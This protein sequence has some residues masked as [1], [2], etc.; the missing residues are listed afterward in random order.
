M[1][2]AVLL[3]PPDLIRGWWPVFRRDFAPPKSEH[4][5]IGLATSLR[6]QSLA[7]SSMRSEIISV[8]HTH[9]GDRLPLVSKRASKVSPVVTTL[10]RRSTAVTSLPPLNGAPV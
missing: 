8:D 7:A 9:K 4:A 2:P 6:R 3:R 10:S 1:I 5:Q